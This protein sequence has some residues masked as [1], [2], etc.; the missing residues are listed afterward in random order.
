MNPKLA[1]GAVIVLLMA[2]SD[3]RPA[4]EQEVPEAELVEGVRIGSVDDPDRALTTVGAILPIRDGRIWVTQP[5][6]AEIRIFARDGSLVRRVGGRGQGPGEFA[7]PSGLGYWG[8][9]RD[10]V[11]VSDPIA[12]RISIFGADGTFGRTFAA[13]P[14]A[15]GEGL[16]VS[17]PGTF[18]PTGDALAVATYGSGAEE[19]ASFPVVRYDP[20]GSRPP[21]WIASVDRTSTVQVRWRGSAVA[22]GAHPVSDAPLVEFAPDGRTLVVNRAIADAPVIGVIALDEGGDTLWSRQY[23][24]QPERMPEQEVDSIY[25][26]RIEGFQRFT[27]L[28]GR[29]SD[30]EAEAAYRQ[31]V[32]I[33]E[34]RPPVRS[35]LAAAD[36]RLWLEWS[37]APGAP[38]TW[39]VLDRDGGPAAQFTVPR[40]LA[41]RAADG[42]SVW[43]VETDELDVPYVVRHDLR[44]PSG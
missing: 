6:D 24:Y 15:V 33:P 38:V 30:S 13:L 43:A 11:W 18:I 41:A 31:S 36:G 39:W 25:R 37:A 22:T 14:V 27:R 7:L 16:T 35:L 23:G 10:S 12:N 26:S 1:C 4:R 5:Q 42:G 40:P 2:C 19:W 34:Y 17:Q 28:E 32:Q 9:D 3:A 8:P 44:E 20:G 21:T 29:L